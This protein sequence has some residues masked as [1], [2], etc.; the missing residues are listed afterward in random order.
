MYTV[1]HVELPTSRESR[2]TKTLPLHASEENITHGRQSKNLCVLPAKS[3]DRFC[4]IDKKERM[5]DPIG[6]KK[7]LT[8]QREWQDGPSNELGVGEGESLVMTPRN[9]PAFQV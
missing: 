6:H 4:R 2:A 9:Q 5:I 1:C 7:N 8:D 3:I